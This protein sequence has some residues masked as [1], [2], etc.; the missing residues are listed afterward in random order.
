[1]GIPLG[2]AAG[3]WGWNVFADQLGVV[4]EPITP[5]LFALLLI[6]AAIVFANLVGAL[7][8]R[9]AGRLRPASVLRTE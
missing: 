5:A 2:I 9:I 3:R 7:P 1:M 6:P 4:P 8:A